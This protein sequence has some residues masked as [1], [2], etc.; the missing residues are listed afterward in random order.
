M[1]L[2]KHIPTKNEIS[3]M[4]P[5]A[6][7]GID[8]IFVVGDSRQADIAF[9]ELM[10]AGSIGFDTESKPTFFKGQKSEGPHVFQFATLQ[11]AFIFQAHIIESIPAVVELLQAPKVEKIGFG[12]KGDLQQIGEKF[13]FRP[14][15]IVDLDRSFRA[16]GYS[17]TLGA[18]SAIAMLF[19][20]KLTK[21]KS[22]TTSNW[23][24]YHLSDSQL[25]YAA[26]D[27]YA[28]IRVH[29]A[30]ESNKK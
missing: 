28:A 19:E 27:A 1:N 24:E 21:S 6:G 8:Q 22:I 14:S 9:S 15:A 10:A 20:R 16:L 3:A 11:K 29:Q 30:L 26:N 12:L 25:I 17:H 23:A 13:G 7:L 5:F 18:K 4:E 2:Y